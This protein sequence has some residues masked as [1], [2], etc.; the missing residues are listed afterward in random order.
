MADE[1][2]LLKSSMDVLESMN[3]YFEA[4]QRFIETMIESLCPLSGISESVKEISAWVYQMAQKNQNEP[5]TLQPTLNPL[6]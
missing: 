3:K 2:K 6:P 4:R 5:L 1:L